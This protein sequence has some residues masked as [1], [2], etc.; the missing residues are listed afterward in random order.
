[1]Q[2]YYPNNF[3]GGYAYGVPKPQASNSQPLTQE[4]VNSLRQEGN[5][6][7]M[8][9]DQRDIWRAICTHK[10]PTTGQNTLI[11]NNDGTYTCTICGERFKFFEGKAEEVDAA[12]NTLNDMFQ[13]C[14]TIY[15]DAPIKLTEQYYQ[16]IPLIKK[17]RALWDHAVNNF[18]KYENVNNPLNP[19]SNQYG[20]FNALGQL[21]TNPYYGMQYGQPMMQPQ[22]PMAYPQQNQFYA[23]PNMN[24]GQP[25]MQPQA[26]MG[27]PQQNQFYAVPNM[28]GQQGGFYAAPNMDNTGNP[29]GYGGVPA[30]PVAPMPGVMPNTQPTAAPAPAAPATQNSGEVQQQKVYNV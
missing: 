24:G 19:I 10:D 3:N 21:L 1:M 6:M 17:F 28:N 15:L 5:E 4:I 16:M 7:N 12:V 26:P 2:N 30:A 27:Y 13:T 14:K 29:L 20:G 11:Q 8:K 23:V 22:A 25:M 9:I 18:S